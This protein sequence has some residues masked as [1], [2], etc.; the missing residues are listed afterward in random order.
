MASWAHYANTISLKSVKIC[1]AAIS[2]THKIPINARLILQ[3]EQ[4]VLYYRT[5]HHYK[6]IRNGT[7]NGEEEGLWLIV[8]ANN[9]QRKRVVRS[10]ARRRIFHAIVQQLRA[11][12]FDRKG[13]K[14]KNATDH[15]HEGKEIQSL[16]G[17]VDIYVNE[18]SIECNYDELSRQAGI[19]VQEIIKRCG[20]S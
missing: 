16:I 19:L 2:A 17:L 10:W 3:D 9:V 20:K 15:M 1:R 13:R 8:G 12:G 18:Q 14:L 11:H 6:D 7:I 4:H 5:F